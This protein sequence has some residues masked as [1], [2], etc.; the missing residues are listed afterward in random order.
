MAAPYLTATELRELIEELAARMF[1]RGATGTLLIV[2]G[3]AMSLGH[4]GR[5]V[6]RDVDG[7]FQ[8]RRLIQ[9]V[10]VE[11]ARERGL[12]ENWL[13]PAAAAFLPLLEP[14]DRVVLRAYPGL[15]VQLASSRVLLAM[16][17]A[18]FR[19]TD[20]PDLVTLFKEL[21]ITDP[22]EAVRI[23]REMYGEHAVVIRDDEDDD[24]RLR[25]EDVLERIELG[26]TS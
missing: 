8:P 20:I 13:S 17:L 14:E 7:E 1:A 3:A 2:G 23:T 9:E 6:T 4:D 25:A 24:L 16:K 21:D 5:R 10:A 26:R 11:M 19:A 12:R 18:A 22:D 15:T